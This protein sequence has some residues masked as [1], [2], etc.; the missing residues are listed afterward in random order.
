VDGG[1]SYVSVTEDMFI[2]DYAGSS[3][4]SVTVSNGGYL[5]SQTRG[6]NKEFS[7][8][9]GTDTGANNNS[10]T[11][12]GVGSLWRDDKYPVLIGGSRYGTYPAY[13]WKDAQDN[14]IN[15]SSGGTATINTA[16]ILAG[17]RSSFNLGDGNSISSASVG[18]KD[19]VV[20]ISFAVADARVN[21]NSGW[22]TATVPG[23][24]ISGA[25]KVILN[26]PAYISTTQPDSSIDSVIDGIAAGTLTKEG[27]GTL[28]LS[29]AN[30]YIGATT[31]SVG[32]LL[33]T[34]TIGSGTGTG[35]VTVN[36]LATLGGTGG[37]LGPVTVLDG[38]IVAPGA[39]AGTLSIGSSLALAPTSIL[40]FELNGTDQTAGGGINDLID[41]VTD[42][43]LD[44]TLNITE[45]VSFMGVTGPE[46]WRLINYTG[47]LTDSG[48]V[49]GTTPALPSGRNF[50]IDTS[51]TGQVNLL[52]P[53]PATMAFV[54]LGGLGLLARRRNRR[55]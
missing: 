12:T 29:Q 9:I 13:T 41:T 32:T 46:K 20:G 34:N 30:T 11:I 45:L 35:P 31:V 47:A 40:S 6:T 48:L 7:C 19:L 10:L 44:G 17:T 18:A 42:L 54:T 37:I 50:V 25:G 2:G 43:T 33:V 49:I 8:I 52:V 3:N 27:T 53:E 14:S 23:A 4:N 26:G 55:A 21:F 24:L 16:V 22:L 38:G 28:K 39:S 1:G 51:V 15:I 5:F 36:S